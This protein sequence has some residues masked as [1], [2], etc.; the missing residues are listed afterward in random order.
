MLNFVALALTTRYSTALSD[1]LCRWEQMKG[2]ST[3]LTTGTDE[4]GQKV[5]KEAE[6]KH[7]DVKKYCDSIAS[8]FQSELSHYDLQLGRFIRTTDPDHIAV[9][10]PL[11]LVG[12][13]SA[14]CGTS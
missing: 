5:Q 1:A 8:V 2:N 13:W 12:S 4:H 11:S 14:K 3:F 9:A 7:M 10:M 6:K